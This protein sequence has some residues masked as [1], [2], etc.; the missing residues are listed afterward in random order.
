MEQYCTPPGG[1][2]VA[3][4]VLTAGI[5]KLWSLIQLAGAAGRLLRLTL[6]FCMLRM[7]PQSS[8]Y[9]LRSLS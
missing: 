8:M 6:T 3:F 1:A 4:Q 2:M 7:F 5:A 9:C